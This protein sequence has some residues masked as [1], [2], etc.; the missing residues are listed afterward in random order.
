MPKTVIEKI[1]KFRKDCL[2]RGSDINAKGYN[3]AAWEMVTKPKDK[4]GLGVID[5]EIQNDALLLKHLHKFYNKVDVP[6]VHLVWSSYY[7]HKVPHLTAD[8][9]SF[10]WKDIL[11]LSEQF[12][13]IAHCLTGRGDTVSLWEDKLL[14]STFSEAFPNLYTYIK[15]HGT[16]LKDC[17]ASS[18]LLDMFRLPMS[19][20]AYNEYIIFRD[21]LEFFR[22]NN[23]QDDIWIYQWNN[24]LFS[25]RQYYKHQNKDIVTPAPFC[26]I[27][28][29]KCMPKIKFFSWLLL[30]DRINTRDILRRRHK[31]LEEGYHCVLCHT[32]TDETLLHLFFECTSSES[33]WFAIGINWN[34][35]LQGDVI[36][37]LI[38]QK[39]QFVGPYFMDLFM[40]AAWCIWK[41]RNDYIFNHKPPSISNWKQ[42]FKNEVKLH[43]YRIPNHKRVVIM[44]WVNML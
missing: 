17:L 6:W 12:R 19:R 39:Q 16:S 4:G 34:L 23:E 35:N 42:S 9:G 31:H 41:E 11:K 13:E 29:T 3:L 30:K 20:A 2:W 1:D 7:Q 21:E 38:E 10:W 28:K 15:S 36:Q 8:K 32:N 33:R 14:Q 27:W 26:W 22:Y 37:M 5:L 44:N 24:G 40:I 18:N 43:L 25:S